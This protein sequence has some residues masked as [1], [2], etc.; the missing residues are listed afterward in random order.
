MKK[1]RNAVVRFT[2]YALL[3]VFLISIINLQIQ[4]RDAVDRVEKLENEKI[5]VEDDIAELTILLAEEKTPD[6]Y[7]RVAREKL[8]YHFPNEILFFNDF[9][10]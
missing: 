8:N 10:Q 2:V 5:A 4:I 6:Y 9:A 7:A 1:T 3:I